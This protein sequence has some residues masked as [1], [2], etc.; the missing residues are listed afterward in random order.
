MT[1]NR[2]FHYQTFRE[3]H[4][5]SLLS[6]GKVKL[7][8]PDKFN[9]PWDCRLHYRV[10]T[11]PVEIEKLI[12]HWKKLHRIHHPEIGEAKRAFMVYEIFRTNPEKIVEGLVNVENIIYKTVCN[13]YRICCLSEKPDVP[14]MWAREPSWFSFLLLRLEPLHRAGLRHALSRLWLV[15]L[16]GGFRLLVVQLKYTCALHR[17]D[18]QFAGRPYQGI[19]AVR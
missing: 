1:P 13:R 18:Q 3:E 5:V 8:R 19:N 11:D 9:D 15:G 2:L 4:L 7:S 16:R 12:E 6:E 10:P 17:L 14:L